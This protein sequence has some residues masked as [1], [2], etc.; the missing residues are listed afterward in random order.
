VRDRSYPLVLGLY[1]YAD[2][3]PSRP[4]D[5]KLKEF[6]RFILS[7][8]GQEIVQRDGKWLPVTAADAAAERAKLDQIIPQVTA[9]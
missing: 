9:K 2:Q 4:L 3:L 8:E 6:F 5:P 1:G 7:R